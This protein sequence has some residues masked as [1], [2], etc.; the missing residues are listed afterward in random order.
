MNNDSTKNNNE[1]NSANKPEIETLDMADDE[2]NCNINSPYRN[3]WLHR[4]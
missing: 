3:C 4:I 2:I 1:L